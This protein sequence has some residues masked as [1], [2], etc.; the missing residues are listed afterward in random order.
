MGVFHFL[1]CTNSTKSGKTSPMTWKHEDWPM[2]VFF[3]YHLSL[4]L[5]KIL[6]WIISTSRILMTMNLY[7]NGDSVTVGQQV[8]LK[9][10]GVWIESHWSARSGLGEKLSSSLI[11]LYFPSKILSFVIRRHSWSKGLACNW[12]FSKRP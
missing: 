10:N 5:R 9:V 7:D 2:F 6:C 11:H 1:N 4:S 12:W 3:L 8:D